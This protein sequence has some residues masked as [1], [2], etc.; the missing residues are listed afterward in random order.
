M[1]LV[2][3]G[4]ARIVRFDAATEKF[5]EWGSQGD[6]AGQFREPTGI[7]VADGTVVVA[8]NGNGRI[9]AFDLDGKFLRQWEVPEWARYVW[10][11]P[12]LVY[13]GKTLYVSSGTSKQI[14]EF[15]LSGKRL[16]SALETPALDSPSSLAI[17]A[18]NKQKHLLILNTGNSTVTQAALPSR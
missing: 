14:L 5:T 4:R 2:D 6:Q 17:A 12:D 8:D 18:V 9:Q 1:Y 13:D 15:D 7:A 11:Y 10:N 3:Q 16:D